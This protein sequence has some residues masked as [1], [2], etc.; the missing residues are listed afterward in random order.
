MCIHAQLSLGSQAQHLCKILLTI[1]CIVL[2]EEITRIF[3]A[4]ISAVFAIK[5]IAIPIG[6]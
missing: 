2:T 4:G 6:L 1:S 3:A 5:T